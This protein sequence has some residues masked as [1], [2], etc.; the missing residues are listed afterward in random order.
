MAGLARSRVE[1]RQTVLDVL[2]S[3]L[4]RPFKHARHDKTLQPGQT[5]DP[6][7]EDELE[8]QV[9][10]TAQR[11]IGELL[12]A[13][14]DTE[15]P[16]YDLDL[17]GAVLEYFDLSGRRIGKL[18]LRYAGLYS[19]TNFSDCEF[20]GPA[21]FTGAGAAKGRIIGFFRC[22]NAIFHERAWFSG[23]AF[24]ERV[25]F[26]GT[27][28]HG[29]AKFKDAVFSKSAE[30]GGAVFEDSLDLRRASFEGPAELGFARLPK[31]LSL[32]ITKIDPAKEHSLPDGWRIETLP[33]G[34]ARLTV[35][36]P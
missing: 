7:D 32:Y 20:L 3:Y 36:Q 22:S 16:G 2:C 1:Y 28:F 12:P 21:Y 8:L 24:T 5:P 26:D 13:A 35:D 9:R 23:T 31:S 30:F 10:L 6:S 4:R 11:L 17:T 18:V 14:G 15:A 33:G 27:T 34:Q 29:P 25:I 19:S